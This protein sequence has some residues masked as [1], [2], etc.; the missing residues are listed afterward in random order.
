M[1]VAMLTPP[2]QIRL[3][4]APPIDP[5]FDDEL[6][7]S[8]FQPHLHEAYFEPSALVTTGSSQEGHSAAL[9]FLNLCVELFNGFRSPIQM[10]PLLA[11]QHVFNLHD[12]LADIARHLSRFRHP[13]SKVK[14]RRTQLRTCEPVPG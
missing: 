13:R 7:P 1:S 10:R 4:R 6:F 8:L 9:R 11:L 2:D 5:P 3:H 14:V 12:E